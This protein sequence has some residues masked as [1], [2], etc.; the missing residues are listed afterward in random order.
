MKIRIACLAALLVWLPGLV[1]ASPLWIDVRSP[2]EYRADRIEGDPNLPYEK[3][4]STIG[5][6]APD[7]NREIVLYCA[8]GGR[9]GVAK[10]TL[11]LMGYTH[12]RNGGGI[13]DVRSDRGC[14]RGMPCPSEANE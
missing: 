1:L 4:A 14:K 7:K 3:I 2:E 11:E 8:R 5:E 9:A 6:L 10:K 13:A 12:V